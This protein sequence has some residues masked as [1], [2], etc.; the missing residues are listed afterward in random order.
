MRRE[1]SVAWSASRVEV[2]ADELD[3]PDVVAAVPEDSAEGVVERVDVAVADSTLVGDDPAEFER[4]L[5]HE[6]ER[7]A[8]RG[9]REPHI[10]R[11]K[12]GERIGGETFRS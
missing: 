9:L 5:G 10:L 11:L 1:T 7:A 4:H 2:L 3:R 12:L 8:A 6:A